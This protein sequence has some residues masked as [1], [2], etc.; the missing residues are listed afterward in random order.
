MPVFRIL[1]IIIGVILTSFYIFPVYFPIVNSKLG[2]AIIGIPAFIFYAAINGIK[3]INKYFIFSIVFAFGISLISYLA[4]V[5]NGTNDYTYVSYIGSMLTWLFGAFCL[6]LYLSFIHK[7]LSIKKIGCYL[8]AAG[9]IQC[10]LAILIDQY[11]SVENFL[12]RYNFLDVSDIN[13]AR[14]ADRLFGVGCSYDPGGIRLACILILSGFLF[15]DFIN[16][17]SSVVNIF[18]LFA[19]FIIEIIGNMISRTTSIGFGIACV[20]VLYDLFFKQTNYV[21]SI[22]K[23]LIWISGSI[24]ACTLMVG[25]LYNQN[26][27]F[28]KNF[29]FGFEGFVS[30]VEEGEWHVTSNDRL[31]DMVRFPDSLHT[32]II[33]DG[34]ID[35]TDN[36]PFY[37]GPRYKG[38]YK[39]TDVGY[40]RFIYYGGLILLFSILTFFVTVT[41]SCSSFFPR[42]K[43]LFIMFLILQLIVWIKVATDIFSVFACFMALG[44]ISSSSPPNKLIDTND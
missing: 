40:L 24:I 11:S 15:K 7:D 31:M 12:V 41:I 19:I 34:Y 38:Y 39:S 43:I 37:T 14:K 21:E 1:F 16:K 2:M 35:T 32:W 18:F 20:Y 27:D 23:P 25:F 4:V 26:S 42:D 33:G 10:I 6:I 17:S 30:L 44:V 22:R 3:G 29:R 5:I 9:A 8:I 13:Y 28:R 36:D